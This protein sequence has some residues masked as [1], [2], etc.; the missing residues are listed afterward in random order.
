MRRWLPKIARSHIDRVRIDVD[1]RAFA[2]GGRKRG[3]RERARVQAFTSQRT[4]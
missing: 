3:D 2:R 4:P 1:R